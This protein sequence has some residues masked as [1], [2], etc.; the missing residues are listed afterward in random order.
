MEFH[1][2]KIMS[3]Q[4]MED[5]LEDKDFEITYLKLDLRDKDAEI[6][7]LEVKLKHLVFLIKKLE[8]DNPVRIEA[9]DFME[10]GFQ[11]N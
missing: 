8:K 5:A 4:E 3:K 6:L 10:N 2:K 1:Q 11:R 7:N 9:L